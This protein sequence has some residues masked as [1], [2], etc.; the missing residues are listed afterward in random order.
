VKVEQRM[1]AQY[2]AKGYRSPKLH[3]SKGEIA[4]EVVDAIAPFH[5]P[6][7]CANL[8]GICILTAASPS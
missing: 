2:M 4:S 6:Q 3:V 8:V 1:E 5:L 7:L